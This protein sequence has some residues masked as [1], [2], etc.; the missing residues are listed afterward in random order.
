MFLK[1]KKHLVI[2]L[3]NV[4]VKAQWS[5]NTSDLDHNKVKK[6]EWKHTNPTCLKK[7]E[8]EKEKGKVKEKR[9]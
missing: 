4:D 6:W 9:L 1:K 5:K 7:K 2:L 3:W 8:K